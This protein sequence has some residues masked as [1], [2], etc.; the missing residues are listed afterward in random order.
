MERRLDALQGRLEV[1]ERRPAQVTPAAVS[2]APSP[3][4]QTAA[5]APPA[6]APVALQSRPLMPQP[7]VALAIEPHAIQFSAGLEA[8]LRSVLDGRKR[9]VR[10]LVTMV[11]FV[12]VGFGGLL[13]ALLQSYAHTPS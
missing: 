9:R 6:P 4:P 5:A 10:L 3:Q 8:E 7:T 11:A 12:L 13:I 2:P 1:L